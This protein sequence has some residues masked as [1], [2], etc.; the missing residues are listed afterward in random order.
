VVRE[1]VPLKH[2][3]PGLSG[4]WPLEFS[5]GTRIPIGMHI[6]SKAHTLIDMQNDVGGA[7]AAVAAAAAISQS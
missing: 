1:A 2:S 3:G 5:H 6:H 4:T 7:M